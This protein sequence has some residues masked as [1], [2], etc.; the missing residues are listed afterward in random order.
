MISAEHL[1]RVGKGA[2]GIGTYSYCS[3]EPIKLSSKL[4]RASDSSFS[5]SL[6]LRSFLFNL[7]Q[8]SRVSGRSGAVS[9]CVDLKRS[10]TDGFG[11]FAAATPVASGCF[12]GGEGG[13]VDA[14]V[15]LGPEEK[16]ANGLVL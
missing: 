8:F 11:G 13:Y 2:K 10:E 4:T 6:S 7:S 1:Q 5:L 9:C 15:P 3:P 12:G 14:D 16:Y